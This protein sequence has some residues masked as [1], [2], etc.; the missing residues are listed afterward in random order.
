MVDKN[1]YIKYKYEDL[2]NVDKEGNLSFNFQ[3]YSLDQSDSGCG[4]IVQKNYFKKNFLHILRDFSD[5]NNYFYVSF[6][7]IRDGEFDKVSGFL[8]FL[9]VLFIILAIAL[10]AFIIYRCVKRLRGSLAKPKQTNDQYTTLETE[11]VQ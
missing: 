11:D 9:L 1:I 5:D 8:K 4:F 10:L 6:K 7:K 3:E 2:Y